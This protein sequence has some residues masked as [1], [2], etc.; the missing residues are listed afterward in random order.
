MV[1]CICQENGLWDKFYYCAVIQ[2]FI[3]YISQRLFKS[4]KFPRHALCSQMASL[5]RD[6][7]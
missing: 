4:M 1:Y 5:E 3:S 6:V 2:S 7:E